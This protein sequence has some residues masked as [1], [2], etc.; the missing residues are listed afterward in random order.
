M[1]NWD[2]FRRNLKEKANYRVPRPS[3][4]NKIV[5]LNKMKIFCKLLRD[6]LNRIL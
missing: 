6:N 5:K 3:K 1:D 4:E 2:P